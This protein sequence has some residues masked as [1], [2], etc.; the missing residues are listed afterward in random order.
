[1]VLKNISFD[2]S[3][4][5]SLLLFCSLWLH[6]ERYILISTTYLREVNHIFLSL[7]FISSRLLKSLINA[8]MEVGFSLLCHCCPTQIHVLQMNLH[9][10][11]Q[12]FR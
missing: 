3:F 6:V 8:F 2:S 5:F 12:P 1:M 11:Q 9:L 7:F 4:L 10:N